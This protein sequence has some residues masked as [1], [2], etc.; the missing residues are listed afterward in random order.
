M[1]KEFVE[2]ENRCY[3]QFRE[4]LFNEY[5]VKDNPKVEQAF[6]LA[7]DRGHSSGYKSVENEFSY[8]V[9]LIK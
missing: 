4:D 2:E 1:E 7:W 9:D 8:L 3:N 5:G 6:N